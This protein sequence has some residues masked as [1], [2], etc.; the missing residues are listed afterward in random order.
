M[1]KAYGK[2]M[3]LYHLHCFM[4]NYTLKAVNAEFS[5]LY[6][7]RKLEANML[8]QKKKVF[9]FSHNKNGFTLKH[10]R[11]ECDSHPGGQGALRS[12]KRF[13]SWKPSPS[14]MLCLHSEKALKVLQF[15]TSHRPK[16][17]PPDITTQPLPLTEMRKSQGEYIKTWN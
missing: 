16:A 7:T 14:E 9:I 5:L 4:I 1:D 8:T 12:M 15:F 17:G 3:F 10:N 13:G 6:E 2:E 11:S